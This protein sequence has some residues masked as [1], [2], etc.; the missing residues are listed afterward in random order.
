MSA[1]TNPGPR[2]RLLVSAQRLTADQHHLGVGGDVILALNDVDAPSANTPVPTPKYKP[3]EI[4]IS[5]YMKIYHF[6]ITK[7]MAVKDCVLLARMA[8]GIS[9]QHFRRAVAAYFNDPS[10]DK[11]TIENGHP[12][13]SFW[14]ARQRWLAETAN[15]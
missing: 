7:Q 6:D 15:Q 10:P 11:F 2:E 9:E 12:I 1:A 14:Y 4:W 13:G 3:T 5:E 8:N